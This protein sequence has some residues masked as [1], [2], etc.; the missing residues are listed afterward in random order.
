[1]SNCL[2]FYLLFVRWE[3]K[4]ALEDAEDS[5]EVADAEEQQQVEEEEEEE[6]VEQVKLQEQATPVPMDVSCS[7]GRHLQDP[8]SDVGT[9]AAGCSSGVERQA[10]VAGVEEEAAAGGAA[11]VV[12]AAATAAA[13]TGI[14]AT[15]PAHAEGLA[16][17][18]SLD[19]MDMDAGFVQPDAQQ[20]ARGDT[21]PAA[22]AAV[23]RGV[24]DGGSVDQQR[25]VVP[26]AS[27]AGNSHKRPR[28]SEG[29]ADVSPLVFRPTP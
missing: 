28:L 27:G 23:T 9:A 19:A 21:A 4:P 16:A 15:P 22:A 13:A 2:H 24:T 12:P 3:Y 10:V 14:E 25:K 6:V 17:G 8:H 11:S 1:L 26:A 18:C 20:N 5:L 7:E 29:V